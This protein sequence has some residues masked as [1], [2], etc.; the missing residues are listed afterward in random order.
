MTSSDVT[1]SDVIVVGGGP[2][3]ATAARTLAAA[4][5]RVR[6]LDRARFPRN[7]PCGG[8]VSMRALQRF[9][10]LPDALARISTHRLSK[11]Y[12][13]APSGEGVTIRSHAPAAL[14]VRR[15][16]FDALLLSLAREAGAVVVEGAE[17]TRARETVPGV[18]LQARDGRTFEAPL[19][20]AADGV[21]SAT[22]R[23]LGLNPGWPAD[24]V[25]LDMMEETPVAELRSTDPDTLWVAYGYRGSEGY[26]Y[27]FPKAAHVNVG[28]GYLLDYYRT[29][30]EAH[31]WTLQQAF[32]GTLC[33]R[34]VLAGRSRREHFTPFL[35][36]VGGPLR[37]T[38]SRR[39]MLAGD[40]GGFVNGITAE[41][42]FYAMV[43]GELAA[44]AALAGDTRSYEQAWKRE[45]GLELRDAVLV[46]RH[47]MTRPERIDRLVR[48]AQS[49]PDVAD[50]LVRYAMGEIRYA[51][52][53]RRLLRRSPGLALKLLFEAVRRWRG[54]APRERGAGAAREP[55]PAG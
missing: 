40:A 15:I 55:E 19:V 23:R 37:R 6:L 18:W 27:V 8:A 44:R 41:G 26:A 14:M 36:P 28:I 54:A 9:P 10:H 11:L 49:S 52:A 34:G 50:L 33:G 21:N 47:L 30:V 13:E 39:V 29:T 25:A 24:R 31:P 35:L 38:A 46:Q 16:E 48:A 51:T 22:A 17:V 42:I 3:G 32:T 1:R 53:R 43:T 4:G 12:L 5:A 7:K 45:I 20:I 2:A